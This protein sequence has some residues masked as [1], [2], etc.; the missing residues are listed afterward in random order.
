MKVLATVYGAG[1]FG[2][3]LS[4]IHAAATESEWFQSIAAGEGAGVFIALVV[5]KLL[6]R[7]AESL[8]SRNI[9]SGTDR[10]L[11]GLRRHEEE[12]TAVQESVSRAKA[13]LIESPDSSEVVPGTPDQRRKA[14]QLRCFFGIDEVAGEL[15]VPVEWIERWEEEDDVFS[16]ALEVAR[17]RFG[18]RSDPGD[19]AGS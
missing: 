3:V 8:P 16:E 2:L 9:E 10:L 7:I 17:A 5:L 19:R 11:Q 12:A 6:P 4:A 18:R 15:Q 1:V 14:A 13:A